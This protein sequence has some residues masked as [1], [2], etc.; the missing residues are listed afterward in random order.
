TEATCLSYFSGIS[1]TNFIFLSEP[2]GRTQAYI[3]LQLNRWHFNS[4]IRTRMCKHILNAQVSIRSP[5][6]NAP[7]IH[8][9]SQHITPSAWVV[10]GRY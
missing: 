6:C 8:T 4:H 1:A 7:H 9:M 3:I 5:C 10:S 2:K